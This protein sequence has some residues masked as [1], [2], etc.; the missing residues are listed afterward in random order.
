MIDAVTVEETIRQF[1][2]RS[3]KGDLEF[4]RDTSL[5]EEGLGLDSLATAEL[6]AALEDEIGT[7]PFSAG[8]M[9]ETIGDILDF[10]AEVS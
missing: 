6:S 3:K 8:E 7:D 2:V 1:L 9:P 5:Y 4:N 10:Y